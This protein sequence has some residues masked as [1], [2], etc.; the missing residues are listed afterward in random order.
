[1]KAFRP[2]VERLERMATDS[3]AQSDDWTSRV[4]SALNGEPGRELADALSLRTRRKM[5]AFFT[6]EVLAQK[7][8]PTTKGLPRRTVFLDAACGVGDLLLAAARNL[9]TR[10]SLRAT[11]DFWGSRLAGCDTNEEFVRASKSR[12]VLLARQRVRT[13]D[14]IEG[15]DLQSVFPLI[16]VRD[17]LNAIDQFTAATWVVLN[18]PYGYVNAP[19]GCHWASGK[20]TAA[21]SFFEACLRHSTTGTR[22]TAI[23]PDVLRSGTRYEQWRQMVTE[24]SAVNRIEPHGLFDRNAD[25][26]VFILDVTKQSNR[27]RPQKVHWL[28]PVNRNQTTVGDL[29]DVHVG[30]VVPHRHQQRGIRVCVPYIHAR[31]IPS[32]ARV[33]RIAERRRFTGNLFRPPF[34]AI[35]RTSSPKDTYRATGTLITGVRAVGVENHLIVCSQNDGTIKSCRQLLQQLKS[36]ETND[37]LNARIRCRHLTVSAIEQLPCGVR[38]HE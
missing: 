26:D 15:L 2:Y 17:G 13:A 14:G 35:R 3:L 29:F 36:Q 27:G 5:G 19:E 10:N 24:Q 6:G 21:A 7:A 20:V 30:P 31:A 28:A 34:V 33:R 1:M 4:S 18:P 23:L 11:L 8:V 12:L 22:I 37:W 32:W 25:V 16:Q 9:P 38:R